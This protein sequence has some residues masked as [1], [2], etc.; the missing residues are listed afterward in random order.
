MDEGTDVVSLSHLV[1]TEERL[2]DQIQKMDERIAGAKVA[3]EDR[4]KTKDVAL[5]TSKWVY[6]PSQAVAGMGILCYCIADR[7]FQD[8]LYRMSLFERES[9][10]LWYRANWRVGSEINCSLVKKI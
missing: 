9:W 2:L 6:I 7:D 8:Q 4:D 5:G 3:M 1:V 10:D